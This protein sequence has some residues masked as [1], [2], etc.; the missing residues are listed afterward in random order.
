MALY[1]L[2]A[3]VKSYFFCWFHWKKKGA[4][5]NVVTWL[6][7]LVLDM[8]L[9]LC[10]LFISNLVSVFGVCFTFGISWGCVSDVSSLIV[11]ILIF[12]C[13]SCFWVKLLKFYLV[14]GFIFFGGSNAGVPLGMPYLLTPSEVL[15]G[16]LYA[17]PG[18]V[19]NL[20]F[21]LVHLLDFLWVCLIDCH[22]LRY[23]W[24]GCISKY[25]C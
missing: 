24:G 18:V 5:L 22:L 20:V 21:F 9:Y 8:L 6:T 15:H 13:L 14:G 16:W 10:I 11:P 19:F 23:F 3:Y 7:L 17:W 1:V 25:L 4:F 2:T 12:W